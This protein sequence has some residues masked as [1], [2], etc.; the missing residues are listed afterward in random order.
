MNNLKK[1]NRAIT[2]F[3]FLVLML[4]AVSVSAAT[5]STPK[6]IVLKEGGE[7]QYIGAGIRYPNVSCA[8]LKVTSS[9][10][11]LSAKYPL[12]FRL[13]TSKTSATSKT[14]WSNL[15]TVK[16]LNNYCVL[17]YAT[18]N[19]SLSDSKWY[20]WGQTDTSLSDDNTKIKCTWEY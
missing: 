7:K 13:R 10:H 4:S 1:R 3:L 17:N 9:S 18:F 6:E 2:V 14:K 20:I 12:Y 16:S 11:K 5:G 19:N 8:R 15:G